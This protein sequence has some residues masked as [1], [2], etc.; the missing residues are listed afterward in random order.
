VDEARPADD[1]DAER[2]DGTMLGDVG[3]IDPEPVDES[4]AQRRRAGRGSGQ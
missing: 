4:A 2:G 1:V 3:G